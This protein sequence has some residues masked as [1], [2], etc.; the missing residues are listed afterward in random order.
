MPYKILDKQNYQVFVA[1]LAAAEPVIAPVPKE[2]RF[3]LSRITNPAQLADPEAYIPTLLPHKKHLFP[4]KENLLKFKLEDQPR[5]TPQMEAPQQV[6]L[7]VR[8]CDINGIRQLDMFF[9]DD[10]SDEHY[11]RRRQATS[12]IGLDCN[13]H[14]DGHCFCE[15]VGGLLVDKGYDLFFSDQGKYYMVSIGTQKG[16]LLLDKYATPQE[17]SEELITAY[18]QLQTQKLS[19]FPIR[20]KGDL[21]S[22]PLLLT[23]SYDSPLWA[24]LEKIDLACG[25]CNVTC[26]T[27]SCFDVLDKL[28]LDLV[29]G[30][31]RRNWDGC[32]LQGFAEV[33]GGGNFRPERAQRVRHRIYRKFK[34]QM[35]KY[36]EP[37]CVGCGRCIRSC[38]VG[39]NP[40]EILNRLF[41]EAGKGA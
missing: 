29:S 13:E 6:F 33:A 10:I 17:A 16:A 34:Y 21:Y 27:C 7:E 32:M 9:L 26:P 12:I 37:F 25:A 20:F 28:E 1:N 22:V 11:A 5:L 36:G 40:Y 30:S 41:E 23:G 8:P 3:A 15:S 31:R 4:A 2:S 14:C 39:I 19:R 35:Q 38:L 24:E 18:K